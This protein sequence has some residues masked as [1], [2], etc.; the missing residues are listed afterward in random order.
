MGGKGLGTGL[1]ALFGEAAVEEGSGDSVFVSISKIEPRRDQPRSSFDDETLTE[2]AESIREHGIIQPLTVRKLDGGYYQIIAGERRWRAA[3]LAELGEVPVRIIEADDRKAMELA[4]VENLQREDLNP[5][6]EAKGY[7]TLMDEYGLT[8]E[9]T[10][11]RV[12]KSRPVVANALRLLTLPDEVL[13][14]VESGKLS[15]SLARTVLEADNESDRIRAAEIIADKGLTVREASALIRKMSREKEEKPE[16]AVGDGIDY[17]AEVEK[18]L[19]KALCRKVKIIRGRK[20]GR[21]EIEYYGDDDFE[22]VS[23]AL[24]TLRLEGIKNAYTKTR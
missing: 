10:A 22:Y 18:R 14:L 16:N 3:R 9:E 2:L 20:K 12:G 15:L 8:Q 19:E 23:G 13:A 21:F 24:E 17:L 7:K 6:E 4:M 11:S 5:V 1:G